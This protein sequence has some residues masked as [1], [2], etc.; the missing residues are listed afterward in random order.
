MASEDGAD[1]A[2]SVSLV[3]WF[4]NFYEDAQECR[5]KPQE[6]IVKAGELLFVPRGWWH[7]ALN[8]EVPALL[9]PNT[10]NP[11]RIAGMDV[12]NWLRAPSHLQTGCNCTIVEISWFEKLVWLCRRA[13]P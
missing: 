13:L 7:M 10:L 11:R 5:V 2:T 9:P 12:C 8:L 6:C 4:L 3:E 1:V